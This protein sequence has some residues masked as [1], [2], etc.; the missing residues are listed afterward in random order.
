MES[1]YD[2][3]TKVNWEGGDP[4]LEL[5]AF[6]AQLSCLQPYA[7]HPWTDLLIQE[8]CLR[9]TP[10]VSSPFPVCKQMPS[11]PKNRRTRSGWDLALAPAARP[12]RRLRIDS[13][14]R[15]SWFKAPQFKQMILS[16]IYCALEGR[17]VTQRSPEFCNEACSVLWGELCNFFAPEGSV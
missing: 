12:A 14:L 17:G 8:E 13:H 4:L 7:F 2:S 1:L 5:P 11:V 3:E 16:F 9:A 6:W 15:L 10:T